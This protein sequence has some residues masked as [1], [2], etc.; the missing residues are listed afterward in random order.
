[1][2]LA[3]RFASIPL[4]SRLVVALRQ[5]EIVSAIDESRKDRRATLG[6][7]LHGEVQVSTLDPVGQ[8][9]EGVIAGLDYTAYAS[10]PNGYANG[11]VGE[12]A[13]TEF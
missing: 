8:S 6:V 9:A 12:E 11:L 10:V 1:M 5:L 13:C 3:P 7:F 4:Y 2:R